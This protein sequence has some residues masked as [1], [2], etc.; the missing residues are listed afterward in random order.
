MNEAGLVV[1]TMMLYQTKYPLTDS[2]P[3][4]DISQWL[5]YQL[6]NFDK[7][8]EVISSD[9]QLRIKR[10]SRSKLHFLTCDRTGSCAT[11]EFIDGKLIYHNKEKMPVKTLTNSTYAESIRFWKNDKIPQPDND[12]SIERF[13]LSANRVKNYNSKSDKKPVEYAFNILKR[14]EHESFKTQ[15]SIVYDIANLSIYF[16]TSDNQRVRHFRLKSFDFSCTTPVKILDVNTDLSEDIA[17]NFID[18]SYQINR[19]LIGYVFLK[20]YF[21]HPPD[22]ILD[23]LSRYPESTFCSE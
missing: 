16:R 6:D 18:F 5:Q 4:I 10:S 19:D 21:A 15:W 20:T 2:R 9:S 8:E 17:D 22:H 14:V 1:E 23:L 7:V 13:L 3:E 11:I 12:Q